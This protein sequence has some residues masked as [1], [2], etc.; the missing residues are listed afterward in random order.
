MVHVTVRVVLEAVRS[1]MIGLAGT[2]WR[3][4]WEGGGGKEE[5]ERE[6]GNEMRGREG[7]KGRKRQEWRKED[8]VEIV[9]SSCSS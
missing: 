2:V 6:G 7:W 3:R 4:G 1:A 5:E 8:C 9:K